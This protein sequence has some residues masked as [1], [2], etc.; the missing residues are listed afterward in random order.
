M[1]Y[2]N[3][4]IYKITNCI[5]DEVYIGSTCQPLTKRWYGHKQDS[6]N[7]LS[8]INQYMKELGFDKFS[9]SLVEN[10]PC[11]NKTELRRREGEF[12][13]EQGTLNDRIAGR[14]D[15]EWYEDNKETMLEYH[16]EY[17][18]N[19]KEKIKEY[20]KEYYEDNKEQA[21]ENRQKYYEN[22]NEYVKKHVNEY[23]LK[24]KEKIKN[25]KS[26][27]VECEVCKRTVSY[28]NLLRHKKTKKCLAVWVGN[29]TDDSK[30]QA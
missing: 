1:D 6:D 19:N 24:N 5:D 30:S 13:K 17:R 28:D 4:K 12:I 29:K 8:K 27:K 20:M 26:T 21:A 3:G 18:K 16:K 25:K 15:K 10:Y 14:T 23:R 22:N 9:I 2:Q 11:T 7:R